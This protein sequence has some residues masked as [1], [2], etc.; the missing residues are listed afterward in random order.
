MARILRST[1]KLLGPPKIFTIDSKSFQN[2]KVLSNQNN[3]CCDDENI[4]RDWIGPPH[5]ISNL[6]R[7]KHHK[8]TDETEQEKKFREKRIEV[9]EWSQKFW[10]KHNLDFYM[11]R[12]EYIKKTLTEKYKD[13]PKKTTLS[14]EEM[15]V[16]YKTFLD[17][18]YQQ[19]V[20]YNRE[21]YK[22]NIGLLWPALQVNI[23]RVI[24]RLS[25]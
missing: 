17:D 25:S 20:W 9:H 14:A 7:I 4:K 21:W 18:R 23:A 1:R 12:E 24:R 8:P 10:E 2:G 5:P 3:Y 6:M 13:M 19:H 15:S 16:F 11:M 22:K